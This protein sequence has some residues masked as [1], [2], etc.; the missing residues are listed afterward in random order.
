MKTDVT[1]INFEIVHIAAV[2]SLSLPVA[3][4][5]SYYVKLPSVT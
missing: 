3:D 5:R 4:L 2:C 1:E